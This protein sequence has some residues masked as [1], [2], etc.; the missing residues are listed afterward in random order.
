MFKQASSILGGQIISFKTGRKIGEVLD[1]VAD[2]NSGQI[3]ALVAKKSIFGKPKK[4]I[5]TVDVLEIV[6]KAVVVNSEES[7]T[8]PEEVVRASE[9]IK[10]KIKL[11]GNRVKTESGKY[12]GRVSDFVFEMPGFNLSKLYLSENIF[13]LVAGEKVI[14]ASKIKK[15][16]KHAV[17]VSDDVIS[18]EIIPGEAE[19]A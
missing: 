17:I 5:S 16:T 3:L 14:D 11:L 19:P 2:S 15:I 18:E 8:L 4:I 13:S 12:L 9:I 6:S 1:F 7:I 10:T